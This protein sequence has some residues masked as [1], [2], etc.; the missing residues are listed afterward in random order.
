MDQNRLV[1][2]QKEIRSYL[3]WRSNSPLF[4]AKL[5]GGEKMKTI[6][7]IIFIFGVAVT[8]ISLVIKYPLFIIGMLLLVLGVQHFLNKTR[9]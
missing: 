4:F 5:I 8:F 1:S 2:D 7:G 9:S 3:I 6:F